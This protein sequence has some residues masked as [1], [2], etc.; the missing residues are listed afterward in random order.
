M[1]GAYTGIQ[2][3][4]AEHGTFDAA[5]REAIALAVGAVGA[6][7]A[8]DGCDYCQAAHTAGGRNAGLTDEQMTRIRAGNP[9]E[10]QLGALLAVARQIAG[11]LGE[12]DDDTWQRALGAGWSVAELAELFTHV[13]VNVFTNYFNHYAHTDLDLPPA[14]AI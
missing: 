6:V 2:A 11:D 8:V 14:P 5:T 9:V 10:D 13:I 4:I 7:G 3:A 1:L 12:V